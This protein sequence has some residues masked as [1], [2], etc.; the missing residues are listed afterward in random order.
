L[1]TVEDAEDLLDFDKTIVDRQLI[2]IFFLN[3]DQKIRTDDERMY[4]TSSS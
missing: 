1:D 4:G 2:R 3:E